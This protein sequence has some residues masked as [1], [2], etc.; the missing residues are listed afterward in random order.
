MIIHQSSHPENHYKYTEN[1]NIQYIKMNE[2][3]L[4]K[5]RNAGLI[6]C[7][8]EYAYIMDDDVC[9]DV[10]KIEKLVRKMIED[11]VAVATCQYKYED[12]SYPKKYKRNAY[13]HNKL[14][15]AKVSSI[16]ICVNLTLL[17]KYNIRFDEAFGLGTNMPSGEEYIFL[18]DCLK[19]GLIVK[20]YPIVTGIHPNITSG[21]DFYSDSSKVLAKREMLKRIFGWKSF[22]FISAFWLKKLPT[23]VRQG[24]FITFTRTLIFGVK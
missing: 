24:Y 10:L 11:K 9:F 15:A 8:S 14:T 7:K 23:V 3:G 4:S 17:K 21:M 1:P 16:E 2:K 5:S 12:G 18:T 22:I 20:Y 13:L 6:N 19:K